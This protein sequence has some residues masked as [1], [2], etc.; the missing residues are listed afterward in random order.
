M[1]GK[2]NFI[3]TLIALFL[4]GSISIGYAAYGARGEI[5]GTATFT[6]NGEVII[7]SAVLTGYQNLLNPEDPVIDGRNI[8]LE[9]HFNVPQ[10]EEALADVYSATYTITITNNSFLNYRYETSNFNPSIAIQ[11]QD[12]FDLVYY[13]EGIEINEIIPALES[14]TFTAT[15]QMIPNRA[16]DYTIPG[17][18][19][20]DLE[21]DQETGT[22]LGTIPSNITGDLTDRTRSIEVTASVI[23]TYPSSKTFSITCSSNNFYLVDS[24]G[25]ELTPYT[26]AENTTDNYTFY[27]KVKQ[28]ARFA[29][30]PQKINIYFE[31][32]GRARTSMGIVTITVEKDET[33]YDTTPPTITNIV[34]TF[35]SDRGK[36]EV[37]YTGTDNVAISHYVIETYKV[38]NDTETLISTNQT[39]ADEE[40]Y[41]ITNLSDGT[42]YF[43]VQAVDTSG[44][45]ATAQSSPEEYR[46]TMNITI[47][48]TNGGPNGTS[49]VDYG[50]N[51]TTTITANNGMNLPNNLTITM[52]EQTLTNGYS[53]NSNNGSLTIQN[54]T[55]DVNV[56]GAATTNFCLIEG[57]KV[58]LANGKIKNIEDIKYD[59]LLL[60]WNYETGKVTKEYPIWIE[61]EKKTDHYTEITFS[62]NSK[63]NVYGNHAFF[64][65]TDNEFV[66]YEDQEKF[67]V[68]TKIIKVTEK[69]T[70][71]QVTVKK[72]K[73]IKETKNYYF[74]AS[75]RYYNIISNDFIT[76]DGYTDITN[77]YPFDKNIKWREDRVVKTIDYSYFEG[78]LPY[79]LFKGFRAG[80]V[81]ILLENQKTDIETFRN[82]IT[83]WIISDR[84]L[85]EPLM[86]ND[87]RIWPIS[88]D[89][90]KKIYKEE[91]STYQLPTKK[92]VKAWYSTSEN[93]IYKP[94]ETVEVWTG[95][96]FESI[97]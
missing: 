27:I 94:N 36:V 96:H 86:K 2:G 20:I 30:S 21:E 59:D 26:I 66:G 71:K 69:N 93:K 16:G 50:Q 4:F 14:K 7:S 41:T 72:I 92:G 35:Q 18:T 77:L 62:D 53:Y 82:Y 5:S 32:E 12:D 76:T 28:S 97:K 49:T 29:S 48:I 87:K 84:M 33:L 22:L 9:L 13:T 78:I 64:S 75:T 24:N 73:T 10:T 54:I 56:T 46:W 79:Y 11:N 91:G 80:E 58:R 89:N 52:G 40:M 45:T 47:N 34:G 8:E 55:G 90:S 15:I 70:L 68:G 1:K 42:Y 39:Q 19:E 88:F 3:I 6:K 74:V 65:A 85:K 37:T 83:T 31:P 60:V 38:E 43:K 44:L 17:T 81:A 51:Y 61:K 67:H 23:N 63:I 95:M 57:T 25:N